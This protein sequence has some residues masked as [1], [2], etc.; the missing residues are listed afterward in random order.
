[1]LSDW[2]SVCCDQI[3]TDH[4]L[5]TKGHTVRLFL[6]ACRDTQRWNHSRSRGKR[7]KSSN[8]SCSSRVEWIGGGV[9]VVQL[10]STSMCGVM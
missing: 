6:L 10:L 7:F 1:M 2:R 9:G 3:Q 5:T 4:V 8:T